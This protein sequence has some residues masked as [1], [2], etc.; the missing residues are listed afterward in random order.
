[1]GNIKS[2]FRYCEKSKLK[3]NKSEKQINECHEEQIK[4]CS[5]TDNEIKIKSYDEKKVIDKY[6]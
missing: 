1:M 5:F 2:K 4:K 3:L 6:L